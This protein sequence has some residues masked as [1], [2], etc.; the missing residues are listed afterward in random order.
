MAT[1][2]KTILNSYTKFVLRVKHSES[3]TFFVKFGGSH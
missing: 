2:T 1:L 3:L